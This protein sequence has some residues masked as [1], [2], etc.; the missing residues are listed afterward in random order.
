MIDLPQGWGWVP[1]VNVADVWFSGVDKKS[2]K[3]EIP[4]RLCNYLDI[5]R[6][7]V[8]RA[9]LDFMNATATPKEIER[10]RLRPGDV[11]FTKDSETAEEIAECS[12]VE[13][14]IPDLLCG[15]HLA[16]ARPKQ[17]L[18]D[19]RFLAHTL[20]LPRV[21]HQFIRATNGVVRFGLTLDALETI[22]VPLA[23]L[24]EQRRVADL[25]ANLDR[26]IEAAEALANSRRLQK[27]GLMQKLLTGEWRVSSE[28]VSA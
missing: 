17:D 15:Y 13:E 10:C 1:L 4:V 18:L 5:L 22:E 27:R 21:R 2:A 25:F 23:P 24:E 14:V 20:R 3:G 16:V 28:A 26:A 8:I 9:H 7:P 11:I 6:N 12:Y 19:G